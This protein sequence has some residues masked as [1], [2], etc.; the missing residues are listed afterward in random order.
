MLFL[1]V[2]QRSTFLG[3]CVSK[4]LNDS[5]FVYYFPIFRR[6][7]GKNCGLFMAVCTIDSQMS[8]LTTSLARVEVMNVHSD[9]VRLSDEEI[10]H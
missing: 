10:A 1:E 5:I 3:T 6:E 2:E 8:H 9:S 4:V 7:V